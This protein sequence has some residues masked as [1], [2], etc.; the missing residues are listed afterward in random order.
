MPE[1]HTASERTKSHGYQ[2]FMLALCVFALI[3][4]TVERAA[5]LTADGR[6]MIQY[7]DF[8][9]CVLFFADFVHSLV[10]APNRWRYLRTWGW[11][12]LLSSIPMIDVLRAGRL[13]RILR[14]LRVLRGLRATRLL[15][16]FLLNRR[17]ESAALVAALVTIL[18]VTVG[19]ASVLH[20]EDVPESNIK[21]PEDA[22]WWSFVTLTTVGYGDRFPVTSEGRL[23]GAL[24]MVMGVGLVG[25]LSG[26]AASWFL[27]PAASRNRSEIELLRSEIGELRR[28]LETVAEASGGKRS[29]SEGR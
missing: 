12:D 20:F 21:T 29:A 8:A 18:V 14:I 23:V 24:L 5:P 28:I 3:A 9:V 25:T 11:I 15:V 26:L 27:A 7:A 16:D 1:A 4:L 19:G 10:T 2:L 13:A 22:L 17:A 6:Q